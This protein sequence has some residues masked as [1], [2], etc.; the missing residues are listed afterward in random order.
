MNSTED[1]VVVRGYSFF[2][3]AN[4]QQADTFTITHSSD[5]FR[6]FHEPTQSFVY[7]DDTN[8]VTTSGTTTS[9]RTVFRFEEL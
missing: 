1:F 8:L 9:D 4:G 7:V 5:M 2:G 6:L 3:D